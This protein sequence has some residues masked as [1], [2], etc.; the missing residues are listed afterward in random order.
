MAA[1]EVLVIAQAESLGAAL[2]DLFATAGFRVRMARDLEGAVEAPPSEKPEKPVVV[3]NA[4]GN[5][6]SAV[7]RDWPSGPLGNIPLLVVG[8]RIPTHRPGESVYFLDLPLSPGRLVELIRRL[9]AT[10]PRLSNGPVE[11]PLA[12]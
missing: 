12:V 7:A 11:H 10:S 6:F 4:A 8:T 2:A 9:A 5:R 1:P 3:V